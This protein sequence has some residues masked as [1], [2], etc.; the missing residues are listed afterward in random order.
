MAE[1]NLMRTGSI[2]MILGAVSFGVGGGLRPELGD[3]E[4][5]DEVLLNAAANVGQSTAHG[6]LV[7]LGI[8][9]VL[10]GYVALKRQIDEGLS[11]IWGRF[12]LVA[13]VVGGGLFILA[14]VVDALVMTHTAEAYA[15]ASGETKTILLHVGQALADLAWGAFALGVAIFWGAIIKWGLAISWNDIYPEWL[16]WAAIVVG[17]VAVVDAVVIAISGPTEALE[18]VFTIVAIVT[19]IWFLALGVYMWLRSPEAA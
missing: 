11:G 5:I 17:L 18:L 10:G 13:A 14:T 1:R 12:A 15:N 8:V 9:L 6:L 19:S 3:P 7:P 16:G 4:V 2:S